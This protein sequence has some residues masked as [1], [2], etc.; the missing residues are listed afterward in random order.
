M[1]IL[2]GED[3]CAIVQ[4]ITGR[5]GSLHTKLMLDYGTCIVAGVT[6]GKGGMEVHGVPVYDTVEEA[7]KNHPKANA[8]IVFV[9]APHA[10]DAVY[11]AVDAGI[12][13]IVVVTEGIPVKD[14][15]LMVEYARKRGATIVGPNTPGLIAPRLRCKLGVMPSSVF[16]PGSVGIV[17]RSGTLAYEIADMLSREGLG[18]S[19]MIG[20]GGDIV[21]GLDF[22]DVLE[23]FK[24]DEETEVVVV[25][26]EVGGDA[27]E[28]LASYIKSTR[29]PKPVVAYVAGRVA[30]EWK[31][32]GHAGAIVEGERGSYESKVRA[33]RAAGVP[34]A[35]TPYDVPEL[36]KS[37]LRR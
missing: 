12:S 26:G 37:V 24:D 3:T 8:S 19:T 10:L 7:V 1:A 14:E 30:P 28:R 9:P 16:R 18:Q 15:I 11:E 31:P 2:V 27:E 34:V 21:T 29:Y 20:V 23:L 22:V 6:P 25:V 36:V 13:L 35:E 33:L 32:L 5:Y 4:G 17:S